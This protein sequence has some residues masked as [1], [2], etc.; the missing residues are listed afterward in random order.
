MIDEQNVSNLN[1]DL[2]VENNVTIMYDR[3]KI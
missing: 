3:G 2:T 1:P